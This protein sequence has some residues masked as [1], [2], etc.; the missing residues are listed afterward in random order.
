MTQN[1]TSADCTAAMRS[2]ATWP[3]VS[4]AQPTQA[5]QWLGLIPL[6][7]ESSTRCLMT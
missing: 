6:T 2:Y 4:K 3:K 7:L 1:E 5:I